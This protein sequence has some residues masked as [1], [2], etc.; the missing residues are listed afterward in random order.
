MEE[1]KETS[2]AGRKRAAS[3]EII[4]A[5]N[6]RIAAIREERETLYSRERAQVNLIEEE[7]KNMG[8]YYTIVIATDERLEHAGGMFNTKEEAEA[9]F[10]SS[11]PQL[12]YMKT[13]YMTPIA[14]AMSKRSA[15]NAY[16]MALFVPIP[17]P[18]I[19]TAYWDKQFFY[20]SVQGIEIPIA[21]GPFDEPDPESV[22][23]DLPTSA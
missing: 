13:H 17:R 6:K 21:G 11:E 23:I 16:S 18:V 15:W 7:F 14:I 8:P 9:A 2:V 19:N 20:E 3:E 22:S 4:F 12:E 5:A 1:S 10:P